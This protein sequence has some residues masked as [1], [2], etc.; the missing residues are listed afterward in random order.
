MDRHELQ[1]Q[2]QCGFESSFADD[3]LQVLV[4]HNRLTKAEFPN[5]GG[6]GVDRVIIVTGVVGI[7][8]DFGGFS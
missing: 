1:P 2:L 4:D 3:D 5:R 7:G 8:L 6:N